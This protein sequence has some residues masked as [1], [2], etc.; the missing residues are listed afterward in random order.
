MISLRGRS[1][2]PQVVRL[3]SKQH[4]RHAAIWTQDAC[5]YLL[6]AHS[7]LDPLHACISHALVLLLPVGML[8]GSTHSMQHAQQWQ[9]GPSGPGDERLPD[10]N[11]V[12][13]A[14]GR[15]GQINASEVQGG[16]MVSL[17]G[18][19]AVASTPSRQRGN[20]ADVAMVGRAGG[21]WAGVHSV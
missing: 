19:A 21:S 17:E 3:T 10:Q 4:F 5:G 6:H 12:G 9:R 7:R 13:Q 2:G 16:L 8:A 18:W 1:F 14:P 15:L 20:M 11:A